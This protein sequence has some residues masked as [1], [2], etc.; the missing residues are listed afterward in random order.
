VLLMMMM[1]SFVHCNL[2]LLFLLYWSIL[3]Y[4]STTLLCL[5]LSS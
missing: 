4:Q 1:N 5:L 3:P 2:L